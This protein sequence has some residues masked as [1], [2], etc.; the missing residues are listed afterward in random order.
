MFAEPE[1][2][3]AQDQAVITERAHRAEH[4]ALVAQWAQRRAEI[5]RQIAWL[6]SQR[7]R[8]DVSAQ[9]HQLQKQ[10]DRIDAKIAG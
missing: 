9:L 3:S 6:Y 5:E 10:L 4:D 2:V 8:K 1:A 7:F